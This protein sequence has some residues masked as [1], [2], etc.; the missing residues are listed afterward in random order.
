MVDLTDKTIAEN[1]R[2]DLVLGRYWL[3]AAKFGLVSAIAA[4]CANGC[5]LKTTWVC[6]WGRAT[7]LTTDH[8]AVAGVIERL[9]AYLLSVD[10]SPDRHDRTLALDG[11]SLPPPRASQSALDTAFQDESG[12]DRSAPRGLLALALAID[13]PVVGHPEGHGRAMD[14]RTRGG[15]PLHRHT[16]TSCR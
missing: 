15:V 6:A 7:D 5:S 11:A 16:A 8:D 12:A 2:D 1:P 14:R 9:D 13:R 3:P 10:R 4:S